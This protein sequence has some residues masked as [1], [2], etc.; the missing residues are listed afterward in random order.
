MPFLSNNCTATRG[1]LFSVRSVP[2][3]Y[4]LLSLKVREMNDFCGSVVVNFRC[5]KL[6]ADIGDSSGIKKQFGPLQSNAGKGVT[7]ETSVCVCV[8]VCN[9]E[10]Q[11]VVTR[12][13]KESVK[14]NHQSKPRI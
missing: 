11:S 8:C 3:L 13:I 1:T 9:S 14:P 4:E 2:R 7:V 5:Y 10:P 6:V 12:C